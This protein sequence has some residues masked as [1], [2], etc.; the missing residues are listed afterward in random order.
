MLQRRIAQG[1]LWAMLTGLLAPL[2]PAVTMPHACCLRH[3]QRCHTPHQAGISNPSCG[4]QC[5]RL[6]AGS[7]T[8][9]APAACRTGQILAAAP[10]TAFRRSASYRFL[11]SGERCQRG[12]PLS[13]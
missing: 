5:C 6:L 13:A 9:F 3:Q 4:H 8:L 2:A 1:V 7:P 11:S 10:L 12:P